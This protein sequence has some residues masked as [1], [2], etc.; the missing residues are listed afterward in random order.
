MGVRLERVR[1][2]ANLER[3]VARSDDV[4]AILGDETFE[5]TTRARANLAKHKKTGSHKV[6]QTKGGVDHYVNL[7]GPAALSLEEGH[8]VGGSFESDEPTYVPGLNI[9]KNAIGG[10]E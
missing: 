10:V 7:E 6:T 4:E 1:L 2:Y 3:V 5:V 8:F 9:L